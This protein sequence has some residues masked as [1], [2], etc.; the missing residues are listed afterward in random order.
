M[1]LLLSAMAAS[2]LRLSSAVV[3]IEWIEEDL[4]LG[5]EL[6]EEVSLVGV[7]LCEG[8]R[9]LWVRGGSGGGGMVSM[10]GL[11]E[12]KVPMPGLGRS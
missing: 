8:W 4:E 9:L 2:S 12:V 11:G 10:S 1:F 7:D 6:G 5:L 3:S